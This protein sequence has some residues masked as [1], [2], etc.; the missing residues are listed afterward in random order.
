MPR[1]TRSTRLTALVALAAFALTACSSGDDP[2][3]AGTGDDETAATTTTPD[4]A[5]GSADDAPTRPT[6]PERP[7]RGDDPESPDDDDDDDADNGGDD[8]NGDDSPSASTSPDRPGDDVTPLLEDLDNFATSMFQVDYRTTGELGALTTWWKN[9]RGRADATY[10]GF[11]VS[12]YADADTGD[13]TVCVVYRIA[14]DCDTE[15]GE[16]YPG[17]P[18]ILNPATQSGEIARVLEVPGITVSTRTI[19]GQEAD[20]AA[21]AGSPRAP[22]QTLCLASSGALLF[23][24]GT[25]STIDGVPGAPYSIEA[26][27]YSESVTDA[28]VTP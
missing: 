8:G 17:L 20:C 13:V 19:A 15:P 7:G 1:R 28:D 23:Y 14:A 18:A 2:A 21:T 27:A 22:E 3:G 25:G 11:G 16:G 9:P 5:G 10:Y 4:P 6:L 24:S 12:V 26:T